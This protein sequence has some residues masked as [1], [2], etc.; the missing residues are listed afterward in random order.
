MNLRITQSLINKTLYY[1]VMSEELDKLDQQILGILQK[2]ARAA[3][4]KIAQELDQPDTTIHF[5]TK[6]LQERNVINRFSAL[7]RPEA[8]GYNTAAI[9]RI[10]IGGHILPDISKER[11]RTFAEELSKQEE[12]LW[13]AIDEEPMIVHALVMGTGSEDIDIRR[14]ALTDSPDVKN[15][16]IIPISKLVKGWEISGNPE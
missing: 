2:D 12:Y 16:I 3:F 6:R 15:V 1:Q 4:T 13:I 7:V 5:R 8:L 9:F 14:E 10:E 11:T